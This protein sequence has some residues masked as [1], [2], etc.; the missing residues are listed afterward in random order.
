MNPDCC[1]DVFALIEAGSLDQ[2]AQSRPAA[3]ASVADL[4]SRAPL[5]RADA[6]PFVVAIYAR[7]DRRP[8]VGTEIRFSLTRDKSSYSPVF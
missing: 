8:L 4:S 7:A 3:V 1:S 6:K 2:A 5:W